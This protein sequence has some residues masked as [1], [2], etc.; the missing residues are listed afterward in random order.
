MRSNSRIEA[1]SVLQSQ[2][3]CAFDAHTHRVTSQRLSVLQL[4]TLHRT[5]AAAAAAAAAAVAASMKFAQT[6]FP[7]NDFCR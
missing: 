2:I 4:L 7:D 5:A 3:L 6:S 1:A